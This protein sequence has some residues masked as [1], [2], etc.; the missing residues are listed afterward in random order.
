MMFISIL[1][2]IMVMNKYRTMEDFS[3]TIRELR[4]LTNV[5]KMSI[6]DGWDFRHMEVLAEGIHKVANEVDTGSVIFDG[7]IKISI[8]FNSISQ[9]PSKHLYPE[10]KSWYANMVSKNKT[11]SMLGVNMLDTIVDHLEKI[12]GETFIET[13]IQFDDP[14]YVMHMLGV[15][16]VDYSQKI[17]QLEDR[18]AAL[19][20][21]Y[22][23]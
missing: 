14:L 11:T 6:R 15:I 17:K 2:L 18:I 5:A 3:D 19:E 9:R 12:R 21:L 23:M 16:Q 1:E 13:D 8:T 7:L 22:S 4:R 10:V 20:S